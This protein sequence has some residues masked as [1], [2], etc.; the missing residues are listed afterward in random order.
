[1]EEIT[2][3]TVRKSIAQWKKVLVRKIVRNSFANRSFLLSSR[4][5]VVFATKARHKIAVTIT[6]IHSER[7]A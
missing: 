4:R 3:E 2:I 1:V 5:R 6:R 7:D